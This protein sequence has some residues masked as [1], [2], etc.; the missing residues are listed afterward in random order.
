MIIPFIVSPTYRRLR[1]RLIFGLAVSDFVTA[2]VILIPTCIGLSGAQPE[3]D[4][5]CKAAGFI[6]LVVV[7]G[8]AL[9]TLSIALTTY[10]LLVHPLSRFTVWMGKPRNS[11]IFG[12]VFWGAGCAP[13][14]V[15]HWPR[16]DALA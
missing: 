12:I 15:T 2:M 6:Y 14:L 16:T 7:I 5:S 9:W 4:A 1:H 11:F 3:N 13:F 8:S 10:A